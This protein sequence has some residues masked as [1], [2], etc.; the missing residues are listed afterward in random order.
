MLVLGPQLDGIPRLA[1]SVERGTGTGVGVRRSGT[2]R[3]IEVGNGLSDATWRTGVG[4]QHR[5]TLDAK[6]CIRLVGQRV[7]TI[8]R[9]DSD[10]KFNQP[11]TTAGVHTCKIFRSIVVSI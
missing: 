7:E 3:T 5:G 8:I 9:G 1:K 11:E 6:K 2:P 10:I 4:R